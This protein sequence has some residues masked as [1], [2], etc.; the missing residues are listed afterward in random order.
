M[1][2]LTEREHDV[3]TNVWGQETPTNLRE[4]D[5]EQLVAMHERVSKAV[6]ASYDDSDVESLGILLPLE[7]KVVNVLY[8]RL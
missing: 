2:E 8:E 3:A 1:T 5:T 4:I 6:Q 7:R